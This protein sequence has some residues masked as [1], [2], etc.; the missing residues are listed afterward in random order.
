MACFPA[1]PQMLPFSALRGCCCFLNFLPPPPPTSCDPNS[2]VRRSGFFSSTFV[3]LLLQFGSWGVQRFPHS[4]V[5]KLEAA[6]P[7]LGGSNGPWEKL[8][9]REQRDVT[10]PSLLLPAP[11]HPSSHSYSLLS[12]LR[13]TNPISSPPDTS[14]SHPCSAEMQ[15]PPPSCYL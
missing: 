14:F 3:F 15:R 6:L 12:C 10:E 5:L 2:P 8:T 9:E 1:A 4:S 7:H 13:A 11:S